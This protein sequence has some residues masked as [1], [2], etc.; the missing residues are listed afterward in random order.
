MNRFGISDISKPLIVAPM[1]GGPSTVQLAAAASNAGG[2][3]ILAGG[4]LSPEVLAER[5]DAARGLTSGRSASTY[6]SLNRVRARSV[7]TP[8]TQRLSLQRPS[9]TAF[10]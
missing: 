9:G 1:A 10:G 2:L 5:I 6:S 8:N 3:G 7:S 4:L